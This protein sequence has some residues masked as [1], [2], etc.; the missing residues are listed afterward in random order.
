MTKFRKTLVGIA[1]VAV[2]ALFAVIATAG[3]SL[4]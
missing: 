4:S 3:A 1:V 2:P